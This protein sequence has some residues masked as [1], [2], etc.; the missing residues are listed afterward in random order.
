MDLPDFGSQWYGMTPGVN[1]QYKEF[2]FDPSDVITMIR[3]KH[4]LHF[5]GEFAMYR[6]DTTP[7]GNLSSGEMNWTGGY[8][9]S[10]TDTSANCSAKIQAA[11]PLATCAAAVTTSGQPYADFLLGYAQS[12]K[13]SIN[14]E[15]GWRL[16]KP[17]MFV[18]DDWKFRPNLTI[19]L[20]FR[21]EISHGMNEVT[22]NLTSFD[23]TVINPGTG[24]LG[25]QW[26]A[27][28]HAN[29]RN[30]LQENV[31]STAL[32]RVGFAWAAKPNTTIRGGFGIYSYN[33]SQD[34]YGSGMGSAFADSG[35]GQDNSNNIFPYVK[36]D[37]AGTTFPLVPASCAVVGDCPTGAGSALPWVT[38]TSPALVD[39]TR[40]NGQGTNYN[41]YHT[42]IPKIYQYSFGVERQL[43]TN[44]AATLSYV[45]SHGFNLITPTDINSVLGA[46]RSGSSTSKCGANGDQTA[47]CERPYPIYNGISGNLYEGISNYNSIQATVTKRF[48]QGVSFNF[49]YVYSHMLDDQDSS[50]WGSRQGPQVWQYASTLTT[51]NAALN[52]GNSNFD[53]RQ[54]FKGYIV[55]Q[56]PFG[57][58]KQ[59]VNNNALA[60]A[61]VG[62]WQVTGSLVESTGNPFTV[63]SQNSTWQA[64]GNQFPDVV[65]GVKAQYPKGARS[66][67]TWF[68]E[69]AFALPANGDY[70]TAHR[71]SLL[72]PGINNV[73][74]SGGKSFSLPWEGIKLAIR[75]DA[76][77]A[78]NHASFA[79]PGGGGA[80]TLSTRP[81][82]YSSDGKNT[83]LVPAQQPGQAYDTTVGQQ[84]DTNITSV[85]V[86]GRTVQL[87]AKVSF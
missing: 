39:P 7:W 6:D 3:G 56:L 66:V 45:G 30:S 12:W 54:A 53:V 44:L 19:N 50:G 47:N 35:S 1:A 69:G 84:N 38:T 57:K 65:P 29:G 75:V 68:N 33:W 24:T 85:I 10:W 40:F 67:G 83:L 58:G 11:T 36:F 80:V 46:A 37:G 34:S 23:P 76:N 26:Y 5:G 13:A 32:P 86:G 9:Q 60:D 21:Y 87:G 64:S 63:E 78:L 25:A 15:A 49:N 71:N 79:N 41:D 16:K 42:P 59:Y 8:T 22:G 43:T 28:T 20:G 82:L 51:N 4:I 31:F 14:P 70:G 48:T 55:Y 72:G 27:S 77:N 61:V 81:A 74:L 2:V 17:Q 62:G 52:Y 18:Q 73:T